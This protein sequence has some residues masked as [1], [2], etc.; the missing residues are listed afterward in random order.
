MAPLSPPARRRTRS[1][2]AYFVTALEI[3]ARAH[4]EMVAAVA[5]FIDTSISKTV[6]VP[7][8]YPYA[9]FED[10]YLTAWKAGL[11]GL[12]TY[13]PNDGA[14]RGARRSTPAPRSTPQRRRAR[15]ARTAASRSR[16]CPQP[17]LAQPALAGARRA[18]GGQSRVD[19]HD[20]APVRRASRSSWATSRRSDGRSVPVRGVGQRR[21]AAA[22]PGRGGEDALDGHA[23]Q[24]PRVACA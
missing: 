15:R 12:A 5:P 7:E 13:R 14:R 21:R 20:R 16:R 8:D 3:S 9:E 19:V 4:K 2:P 1:C 17:V 22:R 24:R 18:A 6:N 11:K 23:R 10:L